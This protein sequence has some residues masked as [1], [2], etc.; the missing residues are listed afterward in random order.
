MR[1]HN[2]C[3]SLRN[4]KNYLCIIFVAPSYLESCLLFNLGNYFELEKYLVLEITPT[5]SHMKL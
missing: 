3:F 5:K 4:K 1:G 2:V